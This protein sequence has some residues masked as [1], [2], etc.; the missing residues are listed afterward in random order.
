[1]SKCRAGINRAA[2]VESVRMDVWGRAYISVY[3]PISL[4]WTEVKTQLLEV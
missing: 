4:R 1:M 3:K 2:A